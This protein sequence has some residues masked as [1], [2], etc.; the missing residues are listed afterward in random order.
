MPFEEEAATGATKGHWKT[1]TEQVR[2][3]AQD[4]L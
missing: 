2:K 3:T 4:F 1:R